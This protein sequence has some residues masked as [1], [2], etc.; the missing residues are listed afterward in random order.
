MWCQAGARRPSRA[1]LAHS[2][3]HGAAAQSPL[4]SSFSP[5]QATSLHFLPSSQLSLSP[6]SLF[7]PFPRLPPVP[8]SLGRIS[9]L[10]HPF[11]LPQ[12]SGIT[13]LAASR[14][15]LPPSPVS[16]PPPA[17]PAASLFPSP[18]SSSLSLP[19]SSCVSFLSP[20]TLHLLLL[21]L[22][23]STLKETLQIPSRQSQVKVIPQVLPSPDLGDWG[24]ETKVRAEQKIRVVGESLSPYRDLYARPPASHKRPTWLPAPG[25]AQAARGAGSV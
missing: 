14:P 8:S 9:L 13:H 5:T 12:S 25:C 22:S 1:G 10:S 17:P 16:F 21:S 18:P 4:C 7:S 15:R 19:P 3:T 11:F 24:P 2:D 23:L 6:P 20:L